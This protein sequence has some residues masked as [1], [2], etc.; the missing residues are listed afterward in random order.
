[1]V[2]AERLRDALR[3]AIKARDRVAVSAL[4]SA[5]AAI[6]NAEAVEGTGAARRGLAIEQSPGLG[7]AE[8]R[9]LDLAEADVIRIVRAEIA[10]R[11]AAARTYASAGQADRAELLLAE[12]AALRAHLDG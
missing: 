11:E 8:V 1:V 12:A 9:R 7:G 5:L 3:A 6:E 4:R 2:L 10:D